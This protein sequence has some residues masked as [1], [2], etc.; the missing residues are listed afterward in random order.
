MGAP[1]EREHEVAAA[2][3][4]PGEFERGMQHGIE[5]AMGQQG[6]VLAEVRREALVAAHSEPYL[7]MAR[8]GGFDEGFNAGMQA[9][10]RAEAPKTAQFTYADVEGARR[11]GYDEGRAAS[12]GIPNVNESSVRKKMVDDMLESC[13]VISESNESMAPG[14]NAVRHM[15]KKLG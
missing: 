14:V 6:R 7:V 3:P 12:A 1:Q 13:R 15:I 5:M 4:M 8:R 10:Q 11:R 2:H 9:A